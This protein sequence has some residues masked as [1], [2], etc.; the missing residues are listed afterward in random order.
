MAGSFAVAHR[1]DVDCPLTISAAAGYSP[2]APAGVRVGLRQSSE[3]VGIGAGKVFVCR[4]I[5][6]GH[7]VSG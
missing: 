6:H 3:A 4:G 1:V 5:R 7:T 2:G